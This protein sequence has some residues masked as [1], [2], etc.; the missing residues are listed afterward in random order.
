MVV[1]EPTNLVSSETCD[2]CQCDPYSGDDRLLYVNCTDRN[3]THIPSL[4]PDN[5]VVFDFTGNFLN[6]TDFSQLPTLPYLKMVS[7][8]YN[9]INNFSSSLLDTSPWVETVNLTG[10]V[11]TRVDSTTFDNME[12]TRS[13]IGVES[14]DIDAKTFSTCKNLQELSLVFHQTDIPES[15]FDGLYLHSLS[16]E[17]TQAASL[18]S[19]IFQFG[20]TSL[21]NL[22][23]TIPLVK[24]LDEHIFHGLIQLKR[25]EINAENIIQL[26]ENLFQSDEEQVKHSMP[27]NLA[28]IKIFGVHILPWNIFKNQLSLERLVLHK[29]RNIPFDLINNTGTLDFLDMSYSELLTIPPGSLSSLSSLKTLILRGTNLTSI[30]KNSFKGL[31]SLI[32]LDLSNNKISVLNAYTFS[33]V[34]N[35][36]VHLDLSGNQIK[37]LTNS[38][39]LGMFSLETLDVSRN[40][41]DSLSESAFNDQG[42]LL[43]LRLNKNKIWNVPDYVL[44]YQRNLLDLNL[45]T[46]NLTNLPKRLLQNTRSLQKLDVSENPLSTFPKDFFKFTRF[47]DSLI[48][49]GIPLHCDCHVMLINKNHHSRIKMEGTCI[50]PPEFEGQ[51]VSDIGFNESCTIPKHSGT[52]LDP[53]LLSTI[54]D[55]LYSSTTEPQNHVYNSTECHVTSTKN[56]SLDPGAGS[57]GDRFPEDHDLLALFDINIFFIV[58]GVIGAIISS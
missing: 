45:A 56:I 47:L 5:T 3:L 17:A 34:R 50:S 6:V 32:K 8:A 35:T 20:K 25:I 55:D 23:L 30:A 51:P 28:E 13:L 53:I 48:M 44:R 18:P 12:Y 2:V 19:H 49:L 54:V 42:K 57:A 11:L 46:N 37:S 31:N 52:T 39:F 43:V 29:I 41:I 10:N 9:G 22:V 21:S 14:L 58:I 16:I 40:V 38:A 27:R 1:L 24:E 26:S 15:I 36:L 4:I 33:S 7:F